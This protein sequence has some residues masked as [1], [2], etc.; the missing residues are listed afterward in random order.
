M[1]RPLHIKNARIWD[2]EKLDFPV[3][4]IYTQNG[5]VVD[6]PHHDALVVDLEGYTIF[7]GLINAHDHLELNH[8]PR[9]KFQH[10]YENAHQWGEDVNAR[11]NE[12]P[13]KSLRA[14]PLWDRLFIGGLKNL[15]CGATTVAH[16]NT[17]YR[18]LKSEQFPVR[19]LQKYG[20][21][22][23]L[24]FSSDED[25][26]RSYKVTPKGASWFIHLA[27][28]TDNVAAGEYQRL[29]KLGCVGDNTVLVHGVGVSQDDISDAATIIRGLVICPSSNHF[30]L[31]ITARMSAWSRRGWPKSYFNIALGSDS[32]LTA[33]GDL[34]DEINSIGMH[35]GADCDTYCVFEAMTNRAATILNSP[36]TGNL[37]SGAYAD[38]HIGRPVYGVTRSLVD[39]VAINNTPQIGDPELMA[40]FPHIQTIPCTLDGVA[41]RI[42]ISLAKQI[43]RCKLKE[44]GLEVD[45]LPQGRFWLI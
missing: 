44:Q 11:L 43:H 33:D 29:K 15:L 25:I 38:I 7:P 10:I 41:K 3:R 28:G 14:H 4:D 24:H 21:A 40:K 1:T 31:G 8:F 19:V 13:F 23:S 18:H 20:W 32:R 5:R 27:E 34:M 26:V 16:H 36:D 6:Q 45:E 2:S 30:L 22:H 39:L 35:T 9:T 42:H 12:E 37:N 17:L